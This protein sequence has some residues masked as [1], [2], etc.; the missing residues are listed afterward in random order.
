MASIKSRNTLPEKEIAALLKRMRFKYR[1]HDSRLPGSP[2]IV[3]PLHKKVIFVH[4]CFWHG[5]KNCKKAARPKTNRRF[6]NDKIDNNTRRDKSK[7]RKL[8]LLGWKSL[9]IWEC[10]ISNTATVVKNNSGFSLKHNP[11]IN[12]YSFSEPHIH[13]MHAEACFQFA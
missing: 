1:M 12:Y 9:V 10:R 2:D 3:L 6:W 8:T 4:G 13:P 11:S 5:H 7:R